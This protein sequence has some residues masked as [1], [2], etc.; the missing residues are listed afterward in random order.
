MST[1][2][3]TQQAISIEIN[4][5]I[6]QLDVIAENQDRL[7][8]EVLAEQKNIA[9]KIKCYH[10]TTEPERINTLPIIRCPAI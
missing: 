1:A 3:Q 8:L 6:Q 2:P 9:Q 5:I 4:E 7:R 10:C